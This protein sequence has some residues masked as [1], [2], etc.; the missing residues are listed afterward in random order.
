MSKITKVIVEQAEGLTED[1]KPFTFEGANCVADAEAKLQEIA[2]TAPAGGGYYKTDV[3]VTLQDGTEIRLRMDVQC[4][5]TVDNDIEILPHLRRYL[6]AYSGRV[7]PTQYRDKYTPEKWQ[8][9]MVSRHG[10][11]ATME[12]ARCLDVLN[13]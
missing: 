6:E 7:V 4:L 8:G 9:L 3:D 5:G 1:M 11:E 2:L 12:L 10:A 13:S